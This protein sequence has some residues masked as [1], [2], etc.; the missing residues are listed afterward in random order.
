MNIKTTKIKIIFSPFRNRKF[1][2]GLALVIFCAVLLLAKSSLAA[3]ELTVTKITRVTHSSYQA[4]N[5]WFGIRD[6]WNR[7]YTRMILYEVPG[8]THTDST[9]GRGIVWGYVSDLKNWTTKAEYEAAAKPLSIG[10]GYWEPLS[11]YWSPIVGEEN[12]LYGLWTSDSTVRKLNIDTEEVNIVTTYTKSGVCTTYARALGF[13]ASNELIVGFGCLN[14]LEDP[15]YFD[16]GGYAINVSNGNKTYYSST[17]SICTS[18]WPHLGHG[19]DGYSPDRQYYGSYGDYYIQKTCG[20]SGIYNDPHHIGAHITWTASNDWFIV[21]D[22][23]QTCSPT[24][25]PC[26][27]TQKIWQVMFDRVSHTFDYNELVINK[28]TAGYWWTGGATYNY[29]A[30]AVPTLRKDGHQVLFFSTDGKWSYSDYIQKG[31]TPWGT[32][33]AFLV[34]LSTSVDSD[35]TPPSAPG[36][37]TVQ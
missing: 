26:M 2:T 9:V 11:M 16:T 13:S 17:P 30:Y 19:H 10:I 33:G 5:Q 28:S 22:N 29:G 6:P 4:N 34:D 20:G 18:G 24:D 8:Y 37:L 3:G 1:L 27:A 15:N 12:I 36:G 7:D 14:P 31:K 35:I 32:A 25:Q 23:M 21:D